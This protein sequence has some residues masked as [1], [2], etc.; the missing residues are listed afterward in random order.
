MRFKTA[1]L[2]TLLATESASLATDR[3]STRVTYSTYAGSE[4][5]RQVYWGDTHLHSLL[6][7]DANTNGNTQLSGDDAFRFARGEE[8]TAHNAMRVRLRRPLDFL[9]VSDHAEYLGVID[10]IARGDALLLENEGARRWGRMLATGDMTPMREFAAS[11]ISGEAVFEHPEFLRSVWRQVVETADRNNRAGVFTAFIG[12]EWTS[13]PGGKNLHRVVL[14]KDGAEQTSQILP[15]SALDSADPE[16]LWRFLADYESKTGGNVFAIPHNSNVSG[17]LMFRDK[18]PDGGTLS[19]EYAELRSTWEPIVEVTQVKGDSETHPFLSP[20]DAFADYETWDASSLG[21]RD[22]HRDEWFPYEYARSALKLGLAI[23]AETG[24]N[25]YRFG[26]IGSTDN[27]T[28]LATAD[29][30]D[31]WGKFSAGEPAPDRWSRRMV[32]VDL[33]FM[34]LNWQMAAS[35]YAAV[36]ATENTRAALFEAMERRET[37][38][39]TGPR[40]RVRFFGGWAF[41]AA[42]ADLPDLAEVGYKKGVPMGGILPPRTANRP[43]SFLVAALK[44]PEGAN[45]DRVQIV[46]GWRM[47][48]GELE[49]KVFDVAASAGRKNWWSENLASVGS[50]VDIAEATYTNDIGAAQL[51]TVWTDPNFDPEQSAFYYLRVIEIPTPRWTTYDAKFFGIE[52]PPEVPRT[53]QE[54]AYTSPIWYS[55]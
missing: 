7:V 32:P 53:T 14:F 6:S 34:Y 29:E 36:W 43:P 52:M 33:P 47:P 41:E 3:D 10:G 25:P 23:E 42:D 54:R 35:G 9:V 26:M 51:L 11:A 4:M 49:E 38:A 5:P 2:F 21:M 30:K 55:P 1:L 46:K 40:M 8:I 27:H 50:T 15:F 31:W 39:T 28:S 13:M 48:N 12:Y 19:R 24:A 37:Y 20:D 45:L 22:E 16:D 18:G 17:G 44:D